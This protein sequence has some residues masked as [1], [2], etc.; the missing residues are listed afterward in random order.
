[1]G[2]V[3]TFGEI[4]LRLSTQDGSTL[5]TAHDLQVHYGGG[6]ANVAVALT[7]LGHASR[8]VTR[9][10]PNQ[11]GEGA[12]R[13]L[14]ANGVDTSHIVRGG[15]N[16]GIY[17]LETGFGGRPSKVIY[18]RKHSAFSHISEQDFDW[19]AIFENACWF[20][21]SGITLA[22]GE[23]VQRTAFRA[24]A[25]AKARGIPVSFDF[26][27]R[28]RLWSLDAARA[29]YPKFLYYVDVVFARQWDA[30]MLLDIDPEPSSPYEHRKQA[31]L[32]ELLQRY[33]LAFVFGTERIIHSATENSLSAY[34]LQSN[35]G[36]RPIYGKTNPLRFNIYDRIGGGDAFAS[37]VL[38]GLLTSRSGAAFSGNPDYAI[39]FGL[40]TSVL[41]HTI[42]GDAALFSCEDVEAFMAAN[43]SAEV[44]R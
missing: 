29:I 36:T 11:L 44:V 13:H 33:H 42:S 5:N 34:Y 19:S 32:R 28:A 3:V 8:F 39:R 40:A 43:G 41:K 21:I 4:M 37:G 30:Q 12:V 15:T 23:K 20:H 22:L 7:H 1:M 16:I 24:A 9:L 26:N 35:H 10:P 31:A 38:H 17:F 14:L 25:E 18:N 2:T 6:E 27:Y